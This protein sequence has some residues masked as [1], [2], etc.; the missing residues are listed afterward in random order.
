MLLVPFLLAPLLLVL[1][2]APVGFAGA[3]GAGPAVDT[4]A[5]RLDAP[6]L[7]PI[8]LHAAPVRPEGGRL[9]LD[10]I[11]EIMVENQQEIMACHDAGAHPHGRPLVAAVVLYLDGGVLTSVDATA[12][13]DVEREVALCLAESARG[14]TFL[15]AE[16]GWLDLRLVCDPGDGVSEGQR[17]PVP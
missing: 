12:R 10:R 6:G 13:W 2:A 7:A 8:R 9:P 4:P 5:V 3:D 15:P 14:W 1:V 17:A 11:T 16:T